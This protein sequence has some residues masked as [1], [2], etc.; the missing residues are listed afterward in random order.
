VTGGQRHAG[1][2]GA[3]VAADEKAGIDNHNGDPKRMPRTLVTLATLISAAAT[4][5]WTLRRRIFA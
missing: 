4:T 5:C 1:R 3:G 2:V